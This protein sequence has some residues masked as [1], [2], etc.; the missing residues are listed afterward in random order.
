MRLPDYTIPSSFQLFDDTTHDADKFANVRDMQVLRRNHNILL[1]Q[2]VKHSVLQ[3]NIS[4]GLQA[5]PNFVKF[6]AGR[7]ASLGTAPCIFQHMVWLSHLTQKLQLVVYAR[8]DP[9]NAES[10]YDFDPKLYPKLHPLH[11][12]RDIY[13]DEC[14]T[15]EDD[16]YTKY[17]VD[18]PVPHT[19]DLE[20]SYNR[21]QIE[22]EF[23][24]YAKFGVDDTAD[25]VVTSGVGISDQGTNWVEPAASLGGAN[26]VGRVLYSDT[27][28][29]IEARTIVR[30]VSGF[31]TYGRYYVH[32]PW[33]RPFL[34]TDTLIERYVQGIRIANLS[35]YELPITE[36]T[37][38]VPG[39]G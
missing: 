21:G 19:Y 12:Q 30:Y 25:G 11:V 28:N 16:A 39:A 7:P 23:A 6:Q 38:D 22:F 14:V 35:L 9:Y 17:T 31:G 36:F 18:F 37:G 1:A 27:D 4:S 13:V 29:T 15:I 24:L 2:R 20:R 8:R 34:S 10:E 3:L 32:S 5:S 33:N 26:A